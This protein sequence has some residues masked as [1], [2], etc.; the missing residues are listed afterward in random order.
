MSYQPELTS[1]HD[2][3][4]DPQLDYDWDPDLQA[5]ADS[6]FDDFHTLSQEQHKELIG[7]IPIGKAIMK[8]DNGKIKIK[9]QDAKRQ[10]H[11]RKL[12][13]EYGKFTFQEERELIICNE[14]RTP[15]EVLD[16]LGLM[17]DEICRRRYCRY[18][19]NPDLSLMV[20]LP[21]GMFKALA[22]F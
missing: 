9:Y 1:Y 16:Q 6:V 18:P 8:Y 11:V 12:K 15:E 5:E 13:V 22:I 14:N 20:H 7:R 21:R 2:Y 17:F 19:P 3:F 4:F 10:H